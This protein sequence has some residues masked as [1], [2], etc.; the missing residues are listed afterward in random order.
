MTSTEAFEASLS[1]SSDATTL[2]GKLVFTQASTTT[3]ALALAL[4]P[5]NSTNFG[6]RAAALAAV[7]SRYRFKYCRFRYL[8]TPTGGGSGSLTALGVI[9]DTNV[10]GVTD[11]P[12]TVG[13][14]AELRCSGTVFAFQSVPT[15]FEWSPADKNFWYYCSADSADTRLSNS[16]NVYIASTATSAADIE[17]DYCIVFKGA[18]DVGT[19]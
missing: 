11:A 14:V 16:G 9:D 17:V 8:S 12:T 18:I 5:Q 4:N 10:S 2:R 6:V 15:V 3:P 19:L 7:F 13:G 1:T